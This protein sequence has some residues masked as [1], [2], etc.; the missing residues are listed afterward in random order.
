MINIKVH[1]HSL[2]PCFKR[3]YV[4]VFYQFRLGDK[5]HVFTIFSD[6]AFKAK[7]T[8]LYS[9]SLFESRKSSLIVRLIFY[10]DSVRNIY[11]Y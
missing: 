6:T 5:C 7:I 2:I 9:S 3:A 8:T 11:Y 4:L 1:T 10:L